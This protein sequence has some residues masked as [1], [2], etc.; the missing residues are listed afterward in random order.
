MKQ[1]FSWRAFISFG[2]TYALIIL[3]LSG[4][5][6]YVSPKGRYA[7]WVHWT[8]WGFTKEGWQAI[9]TI[10]SLGFVVLSIFHLFSINW[11]TF[12]CYLKSKSSNGFNKTREFI[13]ST[14]LVGLFFVGTIYGLPP[15]KNIIDLGDNITA[16]WEKEEER[17]PIPHAELLSLEELSRELEFSSVK[18]LTDKLDEHGVKY[19]NVNKQ[20]LEEI[21]KEN[22]STPNNI[23]AVVKGKS[24]SHS[25]SQG[26]GQRQ[27]QKLS[28]GQGLGQGQ[29][30][31][32]GEGFGRKT[33]EDYSLEL[34]KSV[35]EIMKILKENKIEAQAT[36]TLRVISENNNVKPR[37]VYKLISQ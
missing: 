5:M 36:Q 7:H 28:Q 16:S 34:G 32:Q 2:L 30:L 14:L 27:G 13:I 21:A 37:D 24:D 18:E 12:V 31:E 20:N 3:L 15:F 33:L 26:Q 8:F 25:F 1:K 19:D 29:R 6:L 22:N 4:I 23:H 17:A 35:A 10:F 9:H 11:T